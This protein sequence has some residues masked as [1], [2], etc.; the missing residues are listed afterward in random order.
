MMTIVQDS[1]RVWVSL[2]R[3]LLSKLPE[4]DNLFLLLPCPCALC[5]SCALSQCLPTCILMYSA[6]SRFTYITHERTIRGWCLNVVYFLNQTRAFQNSLIY[7]FLYVV[8]ASV[9]RVLFSVGIPNNLQQKTVPESSPTCWQLDH[10]ETFCGHVLFSGVEELR[11]QQAPQTAE[12][13]GTLGMHH[14]TSPQPCALWWGGSR[15]QETASDG[16]VGFSWNALGNSKL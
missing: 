12:M 14:P 13:D 9:R 7:F 5:T 6:A 10:F 16:E 1:C 11:R 2:S 4:A 15:A 3:L 8:C